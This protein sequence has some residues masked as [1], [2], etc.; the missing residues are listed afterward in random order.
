MNFKGGKT[1]IDHYPAEFYR[2]FLEYI[3]TA[4]DG[5]YWNPLPKTM[6]EFW[7]NSYGTAGAGKSEA[8]SFNGSG[9]IKP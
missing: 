8:A 4:Y 7:R 3:K 2:E 6:A 9:C 5:Q 1:G